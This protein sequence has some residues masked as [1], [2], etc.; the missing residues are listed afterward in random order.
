[1]KQQAT[2]KA[3]TLG[4]S[5]IVFILVIAVL[6]IG[7][8]GLGLSAHIPLIAATAIVTISGRSSIDNR[9]RLR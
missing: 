3:P 5:I 2:A 6:M 4:K 7:I 1:M 8:L 9:I